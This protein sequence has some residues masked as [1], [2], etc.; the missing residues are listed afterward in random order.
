MRFLWRRCDPRHHARIVRRGS[1]GPHY[2]SGERPVPR[3]LRT[4]ARPPLLHARALKSN[5][6]S[7]GD[8][9]S[10]RRPRPPS[11]SGTSFE[12][13]ARPIGSPEDRSLR[14][15]WRP[16]PCAGGSDKVRARAMPE[17]D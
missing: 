6:A 17:G 2:R 13:S 3:P 15:A 12:G 1:R 8:R 14:L 10:D 5:E 9:D 16:R 4:T 11:C 7:L